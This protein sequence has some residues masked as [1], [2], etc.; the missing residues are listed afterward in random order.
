[1]Q[2]SQI[3]FTDNN[4]SP[5]PFIQQCILTTKTCFE[6]WNYKL[7]GL[8][9]AR[10][11][12]KNSFDRTVLFAFDKLAPYAFKADFF[13][14]CLMYEVGGWYLDISVRP[15]GKIVIP[16]EIETIAFRDMQI[17]T[18]SSWAVYNAML[19][20]KPKSKV[21]ETAIKMV[22]RNCVEEYYGE[23]FLCPTGPVVLGKAFASVGVN[24]NRLFGDHV[25]LTPT[26]SKKNRAFVMPDGEIIAFGKP[27]EFPSLK[28]LGA[29]GTNHYP[30]MY[31]N[32]MV[33]NKTSQGESPILR[34]ANL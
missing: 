16:D 31:A 19:F 11:Y 24:K 33:Y 3:Y 5:P 2:V 27:A 10:D 32:R 20:A 12:L 15:R 14:Y 26:H 8:E 23:T 30:E 6:E 34:Q 25:F 22:V 21:Y 29:E 13:R 7:Y 4:N 17:L 1:M 18:Q 28:D 9:D